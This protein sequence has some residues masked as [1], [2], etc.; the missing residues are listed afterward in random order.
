[1]LS[2]SSIHVVR[3]YW[4]TP[5]DQRKSLC[6][7]AILLLL[8]RNDIRRHDGAF[9]RVVQRSRLSGTKSPISHLWDAG[10]GPVVG[11][12]LV[13]DIHSAPIASGIR[14]MAA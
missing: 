4:F 13:E 1:M 7:L 8:V 14:M 12:V 2:P 9:E 5:V 11:H 10:L 3:R 6:Q